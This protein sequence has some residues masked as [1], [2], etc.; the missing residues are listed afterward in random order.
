MSTN[1]TETTPLL[2]E[3][4]PDGLR[5]SL[6]EFRRQAVDSSGGL[7][8]SL[9]VYGGVAR[10][11]YRPGLSD[12]N[13]VM[14]FQRLSPTLLASLSPCLRWGWRAFRLE[15]MLLES[16]ELPRM[17]DTF[18]VKLVDIQR[19]HRVIYGADAF[20]S[21]VVD[22]EHVRLHLE[23]GLRNLLLRLRRRYPVVH[24]DAQALGQVLARVARPLAVHVGLLMDLKGQRVDPAEPTVDLFRKAA[25]ALELD[26]APLV[27]LDGLRH[28]ASPSHDATRLYG[29]VLELVQRL[30]QAADTLE[31][32]AG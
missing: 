6:D 9:V 1:V 3:L 24:D 21:L 2:A 8:D 15:P 18:P 31:V 28:G 27:A 11:R 7:L 5:T 16:G 30:V 19:C 26:A 32:K 4:I 17:A 23:Q 14:L 29:Q 12:V 10:G 22:P 13:V 25:D 20:A